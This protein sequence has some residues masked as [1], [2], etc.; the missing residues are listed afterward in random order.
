MP[1][2]LDDKQTGPG[3]LDGQ[4]LPPGELQ[5]N[6]VNPELP[7]SQPTRGKSVKRQS[8]PPVELEA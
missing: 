3:E 7:G 6:S 2:E 4:G 8:G 5:G 1:P